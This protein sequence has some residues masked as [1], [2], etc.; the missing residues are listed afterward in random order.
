[1]RVY[2]RGSD[3]APHVD[4]EA[5]DFTLTVALC[6][7]RAGKGWSLHARTL[8]G[9]HLQ[10]SP[11]PGDGVLLRG[12]KVRHWRRWREPLSSVWAAYA[13]LHW[14]D[15]ETGARRFDGRAGLGFGSTRSQG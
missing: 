5:C 15:D 3:L 12:R 13:F 11:G 2:T 14:V 10:Y 9:G 6:G 1:M 4:R 8:A 7:V